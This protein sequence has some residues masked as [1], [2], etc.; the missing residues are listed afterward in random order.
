MLTRNAEG[1]DP[2]ELQHREELAHALV[3]GTFD[4]RAW[5]AGEP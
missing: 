3:A 2:A 5:L 4:V 1:L